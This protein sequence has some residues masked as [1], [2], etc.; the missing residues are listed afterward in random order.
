MIVTCENE[1]VRQ[2]CRAL[3]DPNFD[4]TPERLNAMRRLRN[5]GLLDD[6]FKLTKS[7]QEAADAIAR[8]I[9]DLFGNA[10]GQA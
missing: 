7:G 1:H 5:R 2:E 4:G 9:V 10:G 3:L 6:N 8:L